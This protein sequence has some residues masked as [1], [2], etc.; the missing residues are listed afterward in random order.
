MIKNYKINFSIFLFNLE[1]NLIK[2]WFLNLNSS[3]FLRNLNTFTKKLLPSS[4]WHPVYQTSKQSDFSENIKFKFFWIYQ[5][6]R[7]L[8]RE[9]FSFSSL[10]LKNFR[11]KYWLHE[12]DSIVKRQKKASRARKRLLFLNSSMT[13]SKNFKLLLRINFFNIIILKIQDILFIK[14]W[15][16]KFWYSYQDI[17]FWKV[18]WG[19][20]IRNKAK[21]IWL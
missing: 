8:Q 14:I 5:H 15:M 12:K 3:I 21:K 7:K 16:W 20:F 2:H 13:N 11:K 4:F 19:F 10:K 18:L 17:Y 1:I 6:T 9:M